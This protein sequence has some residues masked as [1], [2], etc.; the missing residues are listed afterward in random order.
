MIASQSHQAY[1]AAY[2]RR[3][4]AGAGTLISL[5]PYYYHSS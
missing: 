1:P 2:R 4:T 5:M 3:R